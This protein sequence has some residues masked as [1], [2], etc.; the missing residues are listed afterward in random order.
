MLFRSPSDSAGVV[1]IACS[2][3]S[4]LVT[5]Q[6]VVRSTFEPTP[7][8]T[9]RRVRLASRVQGIRLISPCCKASNEKVQSRL[10]PQEVWRT[11]H[12][13]EREIGSIC[14]FAWCWP[15]QEPDSFGTTPFN[16]MGLVDYCKEPLVKSLQSAV[17]L[18][19]ARFRVKIFC[20]CKT[21]LDRPHVHCQFIDNLC[22]AS[23]QLSAKSSTLLVR[24][25]RPVTFVRAN[26]SPIA[27]SSVKNRL[28]S[29]SDDSVAK[30]PK[31]R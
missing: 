6:F 17:C 4:C 3:R 29:S 7:P 28:R 23:S 5:P 8:A 26:K 16:L 9:Q 27:A 15:L 2:P 30:R 25:R 22:L 24:K 14:R 1:I 31:S 20:A 18:T 19:S 13:G 21:L 10:V 11:L 12:G